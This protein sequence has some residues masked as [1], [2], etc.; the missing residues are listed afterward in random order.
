MERLG[1]SGPVRDEVGQTRPDSPSEPTIPS[2][3]ASAQDRLDPPFDDGVAQLLAARETE[4]LAIGQPIGTGVIK[5][6]SLLVSRLIQ[7]SA[8]TPEAIRLFTWV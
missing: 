3:K 7:P 2:S 4:R 6:V 8:C 5:E 1:D